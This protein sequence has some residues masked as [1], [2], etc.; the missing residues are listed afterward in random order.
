MAMG[1]IGDP[2]PA[3]PISSKTTQFG[4]YFSSSSGNSIFSE[5]PENQPQTIYRVKSPPGAI[6]APGWV[7][8]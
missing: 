2:N 6:L 1:Q 5:K 4:A 3:E 8:V 7:L